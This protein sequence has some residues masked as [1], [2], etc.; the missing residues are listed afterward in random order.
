MADEHIADPDQIRT[1]ATG[2]ASAADAVRS[3]SDCHQQDMEGQSDA[4]GDDDLGSLIGGCYGAIHQIAFGCIQDNTDALHG[5][6]QKLHTMAAN[7]DAGE[8]ANTAEVNNVRGT[9]G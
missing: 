2:W 6:A 7:C 5:H 3:Q 9:L 4:F 1:S 8:Q